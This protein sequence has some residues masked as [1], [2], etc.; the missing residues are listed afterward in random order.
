MKRLDVAV[1]QRLF[2]KGHLDAGMVALRDL[3][4]DLGLRLATVD[5]VELDLDDRDRRVTLAGEA[6]RDG[7]RSPRLRRA[8][9]GDD[10]MA[11]HVGLLFPVGSVVR[12]FARLDVRDHRSVLGVV[13]ADVVDHLVVVLETELAVGA[14][15]GLGHAFICSR[16][17]R[18][19]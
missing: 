4:V 14:G 1:A 16:R 18:P 10:E 8:V 17:R 7:E 5:R 2:E 13:V 3:G 9:D 15:M 12:K 19:V 11:G 6:G